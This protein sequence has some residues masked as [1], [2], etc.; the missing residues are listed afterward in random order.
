MATYV[1]KAAELFG[2]R[3]LVH[4]CDLACHNAFELYARS[5]QDIAKEHGS[6]ARQKLD[7]FLESEFPPAKC[8][9]MLCSGETCDDLKKAENQVALAVHTS[10]SAY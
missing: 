4:V 5:P 7:S 2:Q 6:I 1:K 10:I 3:Y 9:R 8:P